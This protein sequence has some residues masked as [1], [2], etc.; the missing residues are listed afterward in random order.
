MVRG[1]KDVLVPCENSTL[2]SRMSLA[3]AIPPFE[4]ANLIQD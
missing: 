4:R 2:G 1:H 3:Q